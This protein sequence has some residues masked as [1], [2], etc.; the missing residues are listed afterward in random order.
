MQDLGYESHNCVRNLG[1]IWVFTSIFYVRLIVCLPLMIYAS[2]KFCWIEKYCQ[3]LK[4][5]LFFG[6]A[7][8]IYLGAYYQFL[9]GGYM[10]ALFS[11]KGK[12]GEFMGT[13]SAFISLLVSAIVLPG[14]MIYVLCQK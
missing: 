2:K 5:Q 6:E 9:I 7:I 13:Q 3:K 1:S 12:S 8:I 4:E 14:F 10:N 11:L